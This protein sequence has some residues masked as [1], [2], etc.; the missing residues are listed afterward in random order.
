MNP[1]RSLLMHMV[2]RLAD[3]LT[4]DHPDRDR[5]YLAMVSTICS[6]FAEAC[7]GEWVYV[8]SS[9]IIELDQRRQRIAQAVAAGEPAALI[10]KREDVHPSTVRKLRARRVRARIG[11]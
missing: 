11:P 6:V 1:A 8:P 5:A 7:G 10:A 9:N 2:D 4:R 3:R